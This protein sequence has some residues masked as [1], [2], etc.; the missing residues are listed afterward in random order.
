MGA[1]FLYPNNIGIDTKSVQSLFS[2][3]GFTAPAEFI[4]GNFSLIHYKKALFPNI[5]S[6][7]IGRNF[8]F[9]VGTLS[10]KGLDI[11]DGLMQFYED[12]IAKNIKTNRIHGTFAIILF[13]DG[14]IF[15]ANDD[16]NLYPIYINQELGILSSSFLAIAEQLK[17]LSVN[18]LS[19][20]ESLITGCSFGFDTYF[21]EINRFRWGNEVRMPN[22]F[23]Y[24]PL[25]KNPEPEYKPNKQEAYSIQ[26]QA[27]DQWF[28]DFSLLAND[29]GCEVG[30]S[31]GYDSRLLLALCLNHFDGNRVIVGSNYK[32]PPDGD[33]K[34]AR[35]LALAVK[36]DCKEVPI[37]STKAM[38]TEQLEQNLKKAFLFYD[39]QVRANHGWSREYRTVDYRKKVLGELRL[40]L[41]GHA[42]ELLR[43]DYNL[44]RF[45]F[46]YNKWILNNL[47]GKSG[48]KRIG[49][50][51]SLSQL[52]KYIKSKLNHIIDSNCMCINI[53]DA[54]RYYNEAWVQSGP[55]IRASIE[56]QLSY[57][58]SPFTDYSISKTAYNLVPFLDAATFEKSLINDNCRE[59]SAVPYEIKNREF[60]PPFLNTTITYRLGIDIRHVSRMYIKKS[61]Q[62][63]AANLKTMIEKHKFLKGILNN[64]KLKE[65]IPVESY[66]SN[67]A[68][69]SELDRLIA[70]S[71]VVN[72]FNHKIE[73]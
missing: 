31:S 32:N 47:I 7:S 9:C 38:T 20:I 54:H 72:Y 34:I 35:K 49:N 66:I 60:A 13:I 42:G 6:I 28:K 59:L 65:L 21:N 41:S 67:C 25:T 17:T 8:I 58:A 18:K 71:F 11:S 19:A 50:K 46:S 69:E 33:L 3:K 30:L 64:P 36:K 1:F 26:R 5:N 40:G 55:G 16:E 12:F 24:L 29:H 4:L 44:D 68:H 22:M 51:Q 23:H 37:V 63:L 70:F 53:T 15:I 56:N 62:K 27:I 10:Y 73:L 48:Q 2:L 52:I 39:G 61:N 45:K 43:N 57:Y 14:K